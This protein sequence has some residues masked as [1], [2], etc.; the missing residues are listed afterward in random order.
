MEEEFCFQES[1]R[2]GMVFLKVLCLFLCID[3]LWGLDVQ[4][5]LL[6]VAN[7]PNCWTK[8]FFL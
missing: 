2:E 6:F 1:L 3:L 5:D 8:K 4:V 7:F